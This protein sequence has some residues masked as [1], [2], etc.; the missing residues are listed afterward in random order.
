MQHKRNICSC[1]PPIYQRNSSK[2]FLMFLGTPF[3]KGCAVT[4][5][6]AS[7]PGR[8]QSCTFSPTSF[9]S[10]QFAAVQLPPPVTIPYPA[11]TY[12]LH[13]ST[14]PYHTLHKILLCHIMGG[15]PSTQPVAT[16]G[17]SFI[18][19]T[20]LARVVYLLVGAAE[21]WSGRRGHDYTIPN[22]TMG[23]LPS[24]QPV[25]TFGSSHHTIPCLLGVP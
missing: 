14:I 23:V 13:N 2:G 8:Q 20:W 16:L 9:S 12:R 22:H 4:N 15:L 21:G 6:K 17:S 1:S 19:L 11:T 10:V 7:P 24:T 18:L 25:A 5:K 3:T